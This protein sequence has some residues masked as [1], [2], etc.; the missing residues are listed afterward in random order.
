MILVAPAI[1]KDML[2]LSN[3]MK[4]KPVLFFWNENDTVVKFEKYN[5]LEK[6]FKHNFLYKCKGTYDE[7]NSWKS[8]TPENEFVS[9][10]HQAVNDFLN[11]L[12]LKTKID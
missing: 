4:S 2:K 8:H 10:F 1:P 12:K 6:T 7:E 3:S 5:I 9:E 11:D